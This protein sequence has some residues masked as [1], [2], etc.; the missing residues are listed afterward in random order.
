MLST[1]DQ[2]RYRVTDYCGDVH[3]YPPELEAS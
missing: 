2:E 1:P 3:L